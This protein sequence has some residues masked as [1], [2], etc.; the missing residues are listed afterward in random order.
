M[1]KFTPSHKI[2]NVLRIVR[3]RISRGIKRRIFPSAVA[4]QVCS[5][6][7]VG[8]STLSIDNRHNVFSRLIFVDSKH[9]FSSL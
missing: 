1:L 4:N 8:K 5:M 6:Q 9:S 2:W 7:D 3:F